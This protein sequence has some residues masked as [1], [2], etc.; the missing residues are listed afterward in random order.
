MVRNEEKQLLKQHMWL[1]IH[2]LVF[3]VQPSEASTAGRPVTIE[4]PAQ[5]DE[6]LKS[7]MAILVHLKWETVE[8]LIDYV[9]KD[10]PLKKAIIDELKRRV[11]T[12]TWEQVCREFWLPADFSWQSGLCE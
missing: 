10:I 4:P 7:V 3:Q 9:M 1:S 12:L 2:P 5:L 11:K 6:L 8:G